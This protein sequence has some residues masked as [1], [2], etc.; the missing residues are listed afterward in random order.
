MNG[1]LSHIRS[2]LFLKKKKS[3]IV[4]VMQFK[5]TDGNVW[6]V[7]QKKKASSS[8][9]ASFTVKTC[10]WTKE[11]ETQRERK[12]PSGSFEI[13]LWPNKSIFKAFQG[14]PI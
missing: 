8:S 9:L 1:D 12:I 7:L 10:L 14:Q 6:A 3:K 13:N 2:L 5:K 11:T 4:L